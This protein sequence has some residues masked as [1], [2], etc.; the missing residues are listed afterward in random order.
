VST[1]PPSTV[2]EAPAE[3]A[4]T[5]SALK[6]NPVRRVKAKVSLP[7]MLLGVAA[8][9]LLFASVAAITGQHGIDS[10]G[11]VV[12][13]ISAAVPIA[14]AGLGG[15]WAE[16]AGV[17]NIGLE[18][19]MI[20]GSFFGP[21]VGYLVNPWVGI[22]AGI[23]AGAVGGLLHALITVTFGVDHI[24]SGVGINL[25]VFGIAAYLNK[26]WYP[27]YV[28]AGAGAKMSPPTKALPTVT[29][30]GL[31]S[32]LQTV[33]DHHWF[34][35]SD[36][37]GILRGMVYH[38]SVVTIL[39]AALVV[40]SYFIL[41]RTSFGLRLRSCGENPV[42][43]ESLG[44]NVYRYKYLAVMASGG[45]AGLGGVY[46]S[47]VAASTYQEGQT[48]GRG[49]IGLAAMIFGNWRP[50]GLAMGAGLFGFTDSLRLRD[51]QSVHVMLLALALVLALMA[52]WSLYRRRMVSGVVTL[53]LAALV[54]VWYAVTDEV[55]TDLI[56]A[57]PYVVTLVVLT[58]ASQ[59]L[60]MPTADGQVYR[61]GQGK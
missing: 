47:M 35:V 53:V 3:P 23:A 55:P 27:H 22:L 11:Q 25:L 43:A 24:I 48:G 5:G 7:L 33:E 31:A 29:V 51:P 21:W 42:A 36:V 1:T 30:P 45:L 13:A 16:R 57:A 26:L 4:T 58:V 10:S 2:P 56:S 59:R 44:V 60:R 46:L 18:G 41:W 39:A 34:L 61:R 6:V 49:Y 54:G 19:M 15:L 52:L 8:G 20:L 14:L 38:L 17:V 32:G 28:N 37:A 12:G 50:G 9:L 40:A